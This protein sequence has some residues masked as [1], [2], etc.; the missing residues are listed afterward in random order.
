MRSLHHIVSAL[1]I[2]TKV[3][4][5]ANIG[6]MLRGDGD[7][8][9]GVLAEY[10]QVANHDLTTAVEFDPNGRVMSEVVVIAT[11]N[12]SDGENPHASIS[13]QTIV[14]SNVWSVLYRAGPGH[15]ENQGVKDAA[16]IAGQIGIRFTDKPY[17]IGD[18]EAVLAMIKRIAE[19]LFLCAAFDRSTTPSASA[20]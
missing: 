2:L 19:F 3:E 10:H 18:D 12:F 7:N 4:E 6:H 9:P 20:G 17:E 15:V 5:A 8:D 11:F 1:P 13:F 16:T 14:G